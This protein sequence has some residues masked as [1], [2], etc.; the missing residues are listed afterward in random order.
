MNRCKNSHY[1]SAV[2][3]NNTAVQDVTVDVTAT[4]PL[5]VALGTKI[6]DTGVSLDLD[7]NA[8]D[9]EHSGLYRL[10]ADFN[11]L[12]TTAGRL[13]V[14][15]TLDGQVLIETVRLF[16][17]RGHYSRDDGMMMN[18]GMY[19]RMSREDRQMMGR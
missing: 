3:F 4:A 1:K 15:L 6:T 10:S 11:V 18:D 13:G 5:T 17:V 14:A 9:V 7:G 12:G 8:I 19:D 2:Q 16:N